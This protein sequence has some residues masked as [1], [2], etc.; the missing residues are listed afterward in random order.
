M[1]KL[2]F[3]FLRLPRENEADENSVDLEKTKAL[4]DRFMALGGRYF[5]TAYTYMNG[6]SENAIRE[7][8]VKR[9]PREAFELADKLPSWKLRQA[10]D[11]RRYFE[12]ELERCGVEYFDVFLLHGLDQENYERCERLGAFDLMLREKRQGRAKRIGFSYHDS[13]E[14]LDAIL[15]KH[16][17]IELVQLQINYLDW[18]SVT[19]QAR[20]CYETAVRHGKRVI[21]MEPVK[22]GSLAALPEE[23]ERLLKKI[24][25]EE[26]MASWAIR[27]ASSLEAVDIVLSGMNAMEQMEDNLREK[28]PINEVERRLLKEAAQIIR[29]N[30]AVPCTGCG[31]CLQG[32]PRRIAIPQYF[33][34]YNEYARSPRELWKMEYLYKNIAAQR[35]KAGDCIGCGACERACPQKIEIVG[36]LK[37]VKVVFEPKDE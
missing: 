33:A 20:K 32:C 21:V 10:E 9:Y 11:C 14:L 5:D 1:N 31:Y 6:G 13:P 3:G 12:E 16:P 4:V 37:K 30:I 26:S 18:E 34:L 2:G 15:A 27:F 25:P 36:M 22:G 19:I 24:H 35:A 8:L 7:A 17:E 23:A 28:E 29:R